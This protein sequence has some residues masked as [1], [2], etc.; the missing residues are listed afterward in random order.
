LAQNRE[1]LKINIIAKGK[2]YMN[3]ER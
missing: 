3:M 2:N 1:R